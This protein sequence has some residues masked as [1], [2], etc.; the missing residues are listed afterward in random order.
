[1]TARALAL[2]CAST[3]EP[4]RLRAAGHFLE[5][6]FALQLRVTGQGGLEAAPA[7]TSTLEIRRLRLSLRGET[8]G[9]RA[10]FGLQLGAAPASPELLDAWAG[11]R[12]TEGLV[13]RAGQSKTPVSRFRQQ[14]FSDRAFA[15][16]PVTAVHVGAERQ[17]RASTRLEAEPGLSAELGVFSGQKARASFERGLASAW[18]LQLENPSL[19]GGKPPALSV[20][21]ELMGRVGWSRGP[22]PL[23]SVDSAGGPL[24]LHASLGGAWD[25]SPRVRQDFRA[26]LV[27]ELLVLWQGWPSGAAGS[28]SCS[29]FEAAA[30]SSC[31][32]TG[33]CRRTFCANRGPGHLPSPAPDVASLRDGPVQPP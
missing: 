24:R 3:H 18:G 15:D 4:L 14:R 5:P 17:L 10:R 20:H 6:G 16:W 8:A 13:L 31:S 26:R 1:M 22:Q 25:L 2:L 30:T 23:R 9:G 29:S 11:W 21:P 27:P 19:L 12:V 33:P 28:S 32:S 7:G